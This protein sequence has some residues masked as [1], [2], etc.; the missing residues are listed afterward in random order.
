MDQKDNKTI[1]MA[2]SCPCDM[3]KEHTHDKK[4]G[5]SSAKKCETCGH[6]QKADGSSDCGCK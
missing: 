4:D 6:E 1:C 5:E 2:C 3:H